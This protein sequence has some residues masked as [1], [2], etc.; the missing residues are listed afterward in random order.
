V[1][2]EIAALGPRALFSSPIHRA[3]ETASL[4]ASRC[5]V[6]V[7]LSKDFREIEMGAW[8]GLTEDQVEKGYPTDWKM[9]NSTPSALRLPG[10]ETLADVLARAKTGLA[11]ARR[12]YREGA[13]AI[14]THVAVIRVLVLDAQGRSLDEYRTVSV[15]NCRP[16]VLPAL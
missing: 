2:P 9:W 7:H 13:L 1:A 16:V 11:G 8:A 15:P 6:P 12:E 3:V 4:I 10:R 5:S 14:V